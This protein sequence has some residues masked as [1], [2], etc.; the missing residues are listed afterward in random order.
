LGSALWT[1]AVLA[2]A[3]A[4]CGSATD[5]SPI[6]SAQAPLPTA[7]AS[8]DPAAQDNLMLY[9]SN[10]S[11]H[12]DRVHL[13]VSI[14]AVKVVDRSFDVG[15]QHTWITFPMTLPPGTHQVHAVS[16]T[17]ISV[18]KSL[19]IPATGIRYAV[20][21]YWFYPEQPPRQFTFDVTDKPVAFA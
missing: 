17:G 11:F 4:G 14:D 6:Q 16:N 21:S 2:C 9:V 10:Q 19:S 8:R 18:D 3:V 7:T 1:S 20:L 15:T 5:N 13:Q 12:D